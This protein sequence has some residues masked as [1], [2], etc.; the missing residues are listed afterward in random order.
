MATATFNRPDGAFLVIHPLDDVQ[1]VKRDPEAVGPMA[2]TPIV[3]WSLLSL[4]AY[5]LLMMGLVF[6][7]VADM[8]GV[9]HSLKP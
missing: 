2:M 4:R 9:F 6:Y 5:L 3:K 7:H 8:S 1:E